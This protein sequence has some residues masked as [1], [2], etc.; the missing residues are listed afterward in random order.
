MNNLIV[1]KQLPIIEEHLANVKVEATKKCDEALA[2]VVTEDT[3][4]DI[5]KVRTSL[6]KEF[7]ELEKA[8]KDV[9][10]K[11]NQPY[12]DFE[13]IYNDAVNVYKDADAKLKARIDEAEDKLKED[14]KQ[15][16]ITYFNEY[17]ESLSIDF[18]KYEDARINVTLSASMKSLKTE[19]KD[20]LDKINQDI[21]LIDT[22]DNKAEI[23][24]EYKTSL[25]VSQAI[26][27]VVERHKAIEDEQSKITLE[28]EKHEQVQ[29]VVQKVDEILAPPT[30]EPT[31]IEEKVYIA[32]FKVTGTIE[33]LKAL[34]KFLEEGDYLYE[35]SN[36]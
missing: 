24:V 8:R 18:V 27:T 14:K 36:D 33:Q 4:K 29:E 3:V 5:K 21:A 31:E 2:L 19:A 20:F 28:E 11:I 34:K 7:G 10:A 23:L 16:V 6:N 15:K 12:K 30:E 26:T 35:Q 17:A 22:Q 9:K 25:N 13:T 32:K 1:L